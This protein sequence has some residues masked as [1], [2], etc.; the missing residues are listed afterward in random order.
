[1]GADLGAETVLQRGDDSSAIGV[2]L[3]IGSGHQEHIQR[4][5]ERVTAHLDVAFLQ[6]VEQRDLDA[7]GQVWQLVQPE[8]TPVRPRH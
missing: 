4:Q 8:D 2:V 7:F 1:M 6:H 3:R 5:P